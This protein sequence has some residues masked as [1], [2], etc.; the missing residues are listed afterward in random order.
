MLLTG[1]P[2]RRAVVPAAALAILLAAPALAEHPKALLAHTPSGGQPNAPATEPAISG[3]GRLNR[4]AAFTSAATDVVA[5]SGAHRNVFLV[6]R[7]RPFDL[8][9]TT[10]WWGAQTILASKGRSGPANGDSWGASFDGYDY[11]RGGREITVK[12]RCLAFISAA[13][14]LVPGDGNGH[15]DVFLR[16]LATGTLTRIATAGAASE[17]ALDG[18]CS[19]LSYVA[20]GTVYTR[21]LRTGSTQRISAAGGAS[22][23]EVSANGEITTYARNGIV[24]VNRQGDGGM[25]TIGPGTQPT[26][27]EWGRYVAFN[28][29]DDV[30]LANT[31]GAA[32]AR[33]LEPGVTAPSMTAGG[34]FV[35]YVRG[36][37]ATSNIYKSF[38]ACPGSDAL[39]IAGSSHGNYA[40][41]SCTDGALYM[42]YVGG[43]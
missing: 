41:F 23:P 5:G 6:V 25:H 28:R 36:P 4:Y 27:D 7:R 26:A 1:Q 20:G 10:Q 17:V 30:W 38:G 15:A 11:A 18:R 9:A 37:I 43:R 24:Y 31:S 33:M 21:D 19:S 16:Q 2:I 34:H 13:S 29:G 32:Q 39:Q 35:F 22:S 14:N 12:P 3:D 42:S 40:A 8:A